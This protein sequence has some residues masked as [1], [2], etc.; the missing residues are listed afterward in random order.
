MAEFNS[1]K[2]LVK[3]ISEKIDQ[4]E[5]GQLSIDELDQYVKATRDLYERAVVI[6]YKAIEEKVKGPKLD[7][8][9]AANHQS[10]ENSFTPAEEPIEKEVI[11]KSEPENIEFSLFDDEEE[12]NHEIQQ[13]EEDV[14]SEETNE[15][16]INEE[17]AAIVEVEN[18]EV[19]Q[20]ES[21]VEV[22]TVAPPTNSFSSFFTS[23]NTTTKNQIGFSKLDTLIGSFGLNERLQ[24][25]NELF[26]GSSETFSEA[27]KKLDAQQSLENAEGYSAQLATEN[28]WD[29]ESETVEEFVQKICRR[30]A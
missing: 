25:I 29:L 24:Y 19:E 20:K 13:A 2:D 21:E 9:E 27:I 6:K 10:N 16:V 14:I 26:D 22:A 18:E 5:L 28:E 11:P 15:E 12:E 1:Q 8:E 23:V 30:Y 7:Q 17:P 4:L 3:K